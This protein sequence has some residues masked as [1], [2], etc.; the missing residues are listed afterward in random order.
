MARFGGDEFTVPCE[1]I[2]GV[3]EAASVA[4]R[5]HREIAQPPGRRRAAR[6]APIGIAMVDPGEQADH[7]RLVEDSDAAMYRAKE[8]GGARTEL[9]D[10]ATRERA[11]T[12]SPSSRSCRAGSRR[13]S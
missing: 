9:F 5:L 11:A 4:D 3:L 8:R 2:G 6:Q 12:R 7:S 1:S 13:P 10:M